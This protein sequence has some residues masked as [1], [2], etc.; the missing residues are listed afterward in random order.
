MATIVQAREE[1][2]ELERTI[3]GLCS[4]AI[5]DFERKHGMT[6]RLWLT[7]NEEMPIELSS[8]LSTKINKLNPKFL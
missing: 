3:N 5:I 2:E 8:E 7:G 1:M 4:T 6:L